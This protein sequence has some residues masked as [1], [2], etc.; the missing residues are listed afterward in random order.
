MEMEVHMEMEMHMEME[1]FIN[2]FHSLIQQ[3]SGI[4]GFYVTY[5]LLFYF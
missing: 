5:I 4:R 3:G 2:P 1:I